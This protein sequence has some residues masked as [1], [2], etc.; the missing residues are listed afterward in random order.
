VAGS[1]EQNDEPWG[2]TKDGIWLV[3]KLSAS[4]EQSMYQVSQVH[5]HTHTHT[6]AH[7]HTHGHTRAHTHALLYRNGNEIHIITKRNNANILNNPLKVINY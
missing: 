3:D 5:T 2:Y 1:C 7:T 6:H 4:H